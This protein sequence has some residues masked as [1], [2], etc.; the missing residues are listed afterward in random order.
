VAQD[1]AGEPVATARTF[2]SSAVTVL[3]AADNTTDGATYSVTGDVADDEAGAVTAR[4]GE[5][6]LTYTIALDDNGVAQG[7]NR[8]V[9][10]VVTN[11][12]SAKAL[13]TL[14]VS[15]HP[16]PLLQS[17]VAIVNG[18]TN[19]DGEW[20]ITVTSSNPADAS[21]YTVKFFYIDDGGDDNAADVA[22]ITTTY[23]EGDYSAVTSDSTVYNGET[24]TMSFEVADQFET[25][26]D[27]TADGDAIS[28]RVEGT[29]TDDLEEFLTVSGGSASLT[30]TN[31]LATGESDVVT[32]TAYTGDSDDPTDL[33]GVLSLTIYN[34]AAASVVT[35]TD[36]DQTADVV[37]ADFVTGDTGNVTDGSKTTFAGTALDSNGQGVPGAVVTISGAGIQFL[38]AAGDYTIGSGSAVAD[39]AGAWEIDAWTHLADDTELTVTAGTGS[40]TAT[41][42]GELDNAGTLSAANLLFSWTLPSAVAVN[43]TY[44]VDATVTDVWGNPIANATVTFAGEAAAQFNSDASVD[45]TTNAKGVAT[46]YLRSLEDVTGLAAVSATLADNIDFD[47]DAANDITDVGDTFA[48]DADTS[49][50]ESAAS[51]EITAEINFASS[52]SA[53]AASADQK[54]NA[55]SFKGYV[56]LYAKGYAGQRMSAKVGKDWVVVPVLASNFERVVE[57]TGAGYTVAVRIYI[58]RVLVDTIT[59]TTK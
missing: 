39:E 26:I 25:L 46:A 40:A 22:T 58:D 36:D 53:P 57:Y 24:I 5:A 44:R 14:T 4:E 6:A 41:F 21:D 45:K 19:S 9:Y 38:N 51:D 42:T 30:F 23:D 27:E 10:A 52:V 20:S 37:Y 32:V 48:D 29:N 47:G 12:D 8:P 3:E 33:G 49:W 18:F 54:V 2:R 55:G 31:Y 15:G 17:G 43:T 1:A 11:V 34:S 16:R 35:I 13:D 28:I 56:A 59:V 7:A 50:D